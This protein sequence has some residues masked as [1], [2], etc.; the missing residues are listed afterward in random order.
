M[1]FTNL[2]SLYGYSSQ[3]LASIANVLVVMA[4]ARVVDTATFGL[5]AIAV[6]LLTSSTL[7]VRGVLGTPLIVLAGS[8]ADV[9]RELSFAIP[10]AAALGVI[11]AA[12]SMVYGLVSDQLIWFVLAGTFPFVLVQDLLRFAGAAIGNR[13]IA[14]ISD[15]ARF[16][17]SA[18]AFAGTV[19]NPGLNGVSLF[20]SWA[21]GS[22][23]GIVLVFRK[24]SVK[25][26]FAGCR[27]WL[28]DRRKERL[29][30]SLD[31]ILTAI[32]AVAYVSILAVAIGTTDLAAIRGAGTLLGPYNTLVSGLTLVIV[33]QLVRLSGS[34]TEKSRAVLP[35][36][37]LLCVVALVIGSAGFWLPDR[38]GEFFLGETWI[39]AAI[40]LPIMGLEYGIQALRGVLT[41]VLRAQRL[42]G[43]IVLA[44]SVSS[45][46]IIAV[47]L[48]APIFG[49]YV[50]V[51]WCMVGNAIL[52]CVI[53]LLAVVVVTKKDVRTISPEDR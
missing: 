52:G 17:V 30:F 31:S 9:K 25:L 2:E 8:A 49:D 4:C 16:V 44:Q 32:T 21:L 1:R 24:L 20:L 7:A 28:M 12:I 37:G 19:V 43:W 22:A 13:N 48:I 38:V 46:G 26:R 41:S 23:F 5:I 3:L 18:G 29:A 47:A 50:T 35:L 11:L 6:T 45:A 15:L 27:S 14:V 36:G 51:A 53:A 10:A 40:V 33:P 39:L 42:V 34:L